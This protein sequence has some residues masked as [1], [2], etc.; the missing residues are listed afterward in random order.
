MWVADYH[1]MHR[2]FG[3]NE[4]RNMYIMCQ[5]NLDWNLKTVY[6]YINSKTL[7]HHMQMRP[8]MVEGFCVPPQKKKY[9]KVYNKEYVCQKVYTNIHTLLKESMD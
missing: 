2:K 6:V 7:V 1:I 5:N 9:D 4:D 8:R 3:T